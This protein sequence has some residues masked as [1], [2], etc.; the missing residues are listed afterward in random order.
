[1]LVYHYSTEPYKVLKTLYKQG[2]VTADMTAKAEADDL[3]HRKFF[4][5]S[6]PGYYY[7][8]ISFFIGPIPKSIAHYFPKTHEVWFKGNRLFEHVVEINEKTPPFSYEIVEFDDEGDEVEV[9]RIS[10]QV[11]VGHEDY[12]RFLLL[13]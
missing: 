7:E 13:E 8:H 9:A 4:K 12:N 11:V 3:K 2:R 1:M 10:A 5:V 6:R